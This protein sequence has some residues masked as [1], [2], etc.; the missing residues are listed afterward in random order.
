LSNC[1]AE[2]VIPLVAYSELSVRFRVKQLPFPT[3]LYH[4][5]DPTGPEQL[6]QVADRAHQLPF[7]ADVV[8]AA[9]AEAAKT[10]LFFDLSEDRLDDR[11]ILAL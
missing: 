8:F 5:Q 4:F 9:Q 10:A 3:V 2:A 11:L 6:Q 1:G 7:A